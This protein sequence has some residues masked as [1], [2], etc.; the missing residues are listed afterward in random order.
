MCATAAE[1]RMECAI[2]SLGKAEIDAIIKEQGQA[3]IVCSFCNKPYVFNAE[4][5][6]AMRDRARDTK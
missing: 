6:E 5:L 3:E 1:R 4:E 2:V